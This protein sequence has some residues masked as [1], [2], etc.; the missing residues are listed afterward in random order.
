MASYTSLLLLFTCSFYPAVSCCRPFNNSGLV[1]WNIFHAA[2]AVRMLSFLCTNLQLNPSADWEG[3]RQML[4]LQF[5]MN[6]CHKYRRGRF[7]GFEEQN[8]FSRPFDILFKT[9]ADIQLWCLPF[10]SLLKILPL[11]STFFVPRLFHLSHVADTDK[12]FKVTFNCKVFLT[13][14]L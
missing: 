9:C 4:V 5:K 1:L 2:S 11:S 13:L 14:T 10:Q 12:S 3:Q 8:T 6:S 7:Y